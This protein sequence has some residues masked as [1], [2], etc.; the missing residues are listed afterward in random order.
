MT[1]NLAEIYNWVMKG[2]RRL[3]LVGIVEFILYGTCKYFRECYAIANTI[4]NN[5]SMIYGMKMTKYIEDK[6]E[7]AKMHRIKIMGPAQHR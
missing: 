4:L 1:T 6:T 5:A 2:V 7:K 3:P